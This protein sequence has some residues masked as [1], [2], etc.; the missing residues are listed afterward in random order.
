MNRG[1]FFR[2]ESTR[3]DYDIKELLRVVEKYTGHECDLTDSGSTVS[4]PTYGEPSDLRPLPMSHPFR[5]PRFYVRPCYP[6]YYDLLVSYLAQVKPACTT[7][8][9]TPGIG[10][11][12]FYVY[13]V[14]RYIQTHDRFSLVVSAFEKNSEHLGSMTFHKSDSASAMTVEANLGLIPKLDNALYICDGPPPA[15]YAKNMIVFTSPNRN[16]LRI[17]RGY[18]GYSTIYFPPW[19]KT[20]LEEAIGVLPEFGVDMSTLHARYDGFGGVARYCLGSNRTA[21]EGKQLLREKIESLSRMS[22]VVHWLNDES[23]GELKHRLIHYWPIIYTEYDPFVL[24]YRKAICSDSTAEFILDS[25]A[26]KRELDRVE[27]LRLVQGITD[28]GVFYGRSFERL[29]HDDLGKSGSFKVFCI[30]IKG[31]IPAERIVIPPMCYHAT[32]P[33]TESIDGLVHLSNEKVLIL[34]QVTVSKRH[35]VKANGILRKMEEMGLLDQFI[36]GDLKVKL[37]FVL[38]KGTYTRQN[39]ETDNATWDSA[40]ERIPGLRTEWIRQLNSAG[41]TSV[42]ELRDHLVSK[43]EDDAFSRRF[44]GYLDDF[45]IRIR[46]KAHEERVTQIPQYFM[47]LEARYG[48]F[49]KR[50][51]TA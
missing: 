41:I 17:V 25:L 8:T 22:D 13:F 34:F 20:E 37:V 48:A 23:G 26:E 29:C 51:R 35:P 4:L 6:V 28:L 45:A 36:S 33:G 39:I 30:D 2:E 21:I 43:T 31:K 19:D 24:Y 38:D 11:S 16:W 7:L 5:Y 47:V 10:K 14:N 40:I 12:L 15:V 42:A 18:E 44:K 9:G 27:L 3:V 32:P 49:D 50:P 1:H 46:N